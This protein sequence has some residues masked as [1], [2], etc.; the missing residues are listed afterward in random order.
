MA[1]SQARALSSVDPDGGLNAARVARAQVTLA[2]IAVA[3]S[4]PDEQD[5]I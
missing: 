5:V 3:T 1:V 2:N 4:Q